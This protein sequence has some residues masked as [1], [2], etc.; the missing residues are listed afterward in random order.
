MKEYKTVAGPQV[1]EVKKGDTQSA[2]NLFADIMNE[3]ASTAG[4]T[5]LWK[6]LPSPKNPAVFPSPPPC[7]ITC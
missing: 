1:I 5:T 2:F 4:T 3:Q 6:P 7:I